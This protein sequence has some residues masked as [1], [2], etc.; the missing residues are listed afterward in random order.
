VAAGINPLELG[1]SR[2]LLGHWTGHCPANT[3]GSCASRG[4][5]RAPGQAAG[6]LLAAWAH[7]RNLLAEALFHADHLTEYV[8]GTTAAEVVRPYGVA[9]SSVL[10]LVRQTGDRYDSPAQQQ[11]DGS[12]GCPVSGGVVPEGHCGT[13][14]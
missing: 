5:W 8:G 14:G 9:K 4:W 7:V 11:S 10:Q 13:T 6:G 2:P 12:T 3:S 1:G